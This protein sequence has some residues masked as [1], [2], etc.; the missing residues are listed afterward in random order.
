MDWI[1]IVLLALVVAP[2][3]L[4]PFV[5]RLSAWRP[6]DHGL[7]AVAEAEVPEDI[8]NN[9]AP[10]VAD[11]RGVG[12]DFVTYVS[13]PGPE[14]VA[15]T[16][17]ALLLHPANK[18]M[19]IAVS[20]GPKVGLRFRYVEFS[21]EFTDGQE[22]NTLNS[23][24]LGCF[25]D[26]PMKKKFPFPDVADARVLYEAHRRLIREQF[27]AASPRLPWQGREVDEVAASMRK[28]MEKQVEYGYFDL[29]DT[30]QKF[31]PSW[32]GAHVMT[33]KLVWP[34]G[35]IRK[36][37]ARDRAEKTLKRLGLA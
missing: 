30:K 8:R 25:R 26:D 5:M 15:T 31:K 17:F 7:K 18:D 16:W 33:W 13:M 37:A 29:D 14:M 21:T 20:M 22:I 9:L 10:L 32:Y 12:F 2:A 19:A 34:I 4:T 3:L 28:Q 27:P 23:P 35:W 1:W 24:Q 11:L 36:A 6:L